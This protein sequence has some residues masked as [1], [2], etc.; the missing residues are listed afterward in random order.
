MKL[1]HGSRAIATGSLLSLSVTAALLSGAAGARHDAQ[2]T[3]SHVGTVHVRSDDDWPRTSSVTGAV[4]A[5]DDW[6]TSGV[7][8]TQTVGF[9]LHK[10]AVV[11]A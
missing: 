8:T 5:D 11:R 2:R 1:G 7:T 9:T 3:P 6:P 4:S 10:S